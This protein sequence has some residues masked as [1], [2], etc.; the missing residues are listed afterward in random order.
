M[1]GKKTNKLITTESDP[2]LS[3]IFTFIHKIYMFFYT[4][5]LD[6]KNFE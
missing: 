2:F 6:Q 5:Y 1:Y 3:S 4:I